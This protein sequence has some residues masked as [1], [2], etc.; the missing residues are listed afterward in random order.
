MKTMSKTICIALVLLLSSFV[1]ASGLTYAESYP[2][3]NEIQ[4]NIEKEY[5]VN[6]IIA[7]NNNFSSANLEKCLTDVDRCL[8]YFPEGVIKEI[9]GTYSKKGVKTNIII[10][11]SEYGTVKNQVV[12]IKSEKSVDITINIMSNSICGMYDTFSTDGVMHELGHF[13][14]DYLFECYGQ[15]K[16]EREFEKLNGQYSYGTWGDGYTNVFVSKNSAV[17]LNDDI[18]DLIWYAEVHPDKLR[19]LGKKQIIHNKIEHLANVLDSCFE[20]VTNDSRI[21]LDA[22]PNVPDEWAEDIIE[23][24]K[25]KGLIPE[26]FE[27]KYEP[28]ISRE[29]FYVLCVHMIKVHVGE[30]EFYSY[31]NITKP[32]KCFNIDP[33]SGE[34]ILDD[35]ISSSFYKINMFKQKEIIYDAYAIG[36]INDMEEE[37]LEPG[38]YIT[39][40]DAAKVIYYIYEK[41]NE[42]AFKNNELK[43]G[44]ID[45]LSDIEKLYVNFVASKG[46]VSADGNEINPYEYCTYQESYI[47]LNN[48]FK[49]LDK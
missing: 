30:Q 3:I 41:F 18:S 47:L 28:Y 1:T 26:N 2:E 38:D 37:N 7:N 29:D 32:E 9:A 17:C 43:N 27:G 44:D 8:S 19:N 13:V 33:I 24:M 11:K 5:G 35:K 4:K 12:Y 15:D 46:L 48:L 45:N 31:F 23:E 49:M 10:K 25:N 14:C 42:D 21:W 16:L 40:L 34:V 6:I 20:S 22:I 36:L 39:K